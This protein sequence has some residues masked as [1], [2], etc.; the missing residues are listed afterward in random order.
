VLP[1]DEFNLLVNWLADEL[2]KLD[3]VEIPVEDLVAN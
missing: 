2:A 1:E 3:N